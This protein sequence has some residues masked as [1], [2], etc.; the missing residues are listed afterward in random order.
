M[1]YKRKLFAREL[2]AQDTLFEAI[3]ICSSVESKVR[4]RLPLTCQIDYCGFRA[5]VIAVPPIE[6]DQGLSLGFN[7]EGHF[8]IMD[9]QLKNELKYVGNVL[10]LKEYQTKYK[11]QKLS[12]YSQQIQ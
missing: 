1:P 7:H 8:E 11:Q 3:F 10:N 12:Q 2:L 9:Y 6:P 4:I 5:L